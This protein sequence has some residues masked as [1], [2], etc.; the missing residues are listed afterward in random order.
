M[1]AMEKQ[2]G[3]IFSGGGA[4]GSYEIGV[5]HALKELGFEKK[6]TAVSGASVGSLNAALFAAGDYKR[7]EDIWKKVTPLWFLDL[8]S[9]EI[10]IQSLAIT[11]YIKD[12][13]E[14]RKNGGIFSREGLLDIM[15]YDIDLQ[16]VSES[17]CNVY[18][19]ASYEHRGRNQIEY[20]HLN[21]MGKEE[22]KEVLLASSAM[23]FIYEPVNINGVLY[24][25]GGIVDNIPVYPLVRDGFHHLIVVK[26]EKNGYVE[27]SLYKNREVIEIVPSKDLGN[28]FDGTIDFSHQNILKR[29][30]LGYHDALE[31]LNSY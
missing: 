9:Q 16:V 19:N 14:D 17:K 28:F 31:I 4:K 8:N 2:W 7:A 23:P 11:D 29:M 15:K 10:M 25:D 5:W 13:L 1:K 18:A 30:E 12:L 26:L 27:K 21:G 6:I 22:I 3:L 24:R 20:F